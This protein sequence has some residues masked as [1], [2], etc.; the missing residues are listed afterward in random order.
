MFVV[1]L[2]L[3]LINSK[4][5]LC[6]IMIKL[7][8]NAL[9]MNIN[10]VHQWYTLVINHNSLTMSFTIDKLTIIDRLFILFYF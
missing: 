2:P 3:P 8:I 10:T 1:I 7:N 6:N 5:N 9:L 4:L